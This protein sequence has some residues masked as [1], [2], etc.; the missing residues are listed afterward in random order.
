MDIYFIL[1]VMIQCYF[2]WLCSI[3]HL[4]PF[5]ALS[6][7]SCVPVSIPTIV[8]F[9]FVCLLA[10]FFFFF[11]NGSFLSCTMWCYKLI[12]CTSCSRPRIS[13]SSKK[14]W[15]LLLENGMRNQ[16]LC[17]KC[18]HYYWCVVASWPFQLTEQGNMWY[19]LMTV[20]THI[21]TYFYRCNHLYL[22]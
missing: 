14:L 22:Y 16:D 5:G 20:Y 18:A 11:F 4:W 1:C 9:L 6:V 2:I 17:T 12:L 15:F 8:G 10:F 13:H 7:S 3:F 19:I 21:Y